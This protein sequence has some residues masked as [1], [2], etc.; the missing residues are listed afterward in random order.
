M[1]VERTFPLAGIAQ[2]HRASETAHVR[3]RLV[4]MIG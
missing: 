2:A 4:L 1:P 3:G